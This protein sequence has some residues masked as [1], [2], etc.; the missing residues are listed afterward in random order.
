MSKK[1]FPSANAWWC[2]IKICPSTPKARCEKQKNRPETQAVKKRLC[3]LLAQ[4][5][6]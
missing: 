3:W 4:F 2:L 1:S 6:A 5:M